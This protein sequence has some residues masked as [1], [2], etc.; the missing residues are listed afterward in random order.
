MIIRVSSEI[1]RR[2]SCRAVACSCASF[3]RFL[4]PL[5]SG[6]PEQPRKASPLV[7]F[8]LSFIVFLH[9]GHFSLEQS[10]SV[11][12]A[13]MGQMVV[14]FSSGGAMSWDRLASML[15]LRIPADLAGTPR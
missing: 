5:H 8:L 15:R 3:D 7:R 9:F 2:D 10:T 13:Q 1:T 14:A 12:W 6:Y 11:G 4:V